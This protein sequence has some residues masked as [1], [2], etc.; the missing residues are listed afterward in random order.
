M[1]VSNY[2][3]ERKRE[4]FE[5]TP[6]MNLS[7]TSAWTELVIVNELGLRAIYFNELKP[8]MHVSNY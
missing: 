3:V 7:T 4:F 1:H 8:Y 6:K 2:G 5:E